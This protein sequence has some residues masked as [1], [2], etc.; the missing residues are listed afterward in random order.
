MTKSGDGIDMKYITMVYLQWFVYAAYGV[1]YDANNVSISLPVYMY[2]PIMD[3]G[4]ETLTVLFTFPAPLL[5]T[6]H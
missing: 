3:V 6:H 4:I 2:V 1:L 5:N